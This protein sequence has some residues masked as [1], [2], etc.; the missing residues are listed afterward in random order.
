MKYWLFLCLFFC[1]LGLYAQDIAADTTIYDVLEEMPRFP[2]CE[3]LDTTV[4]AKNTCAQ[5]QLLAFVNKNIVYPV[6]A[7]QLGAEGMVVVKFTVEKDGTLS[8]PSVLKNV[9][10]GCG[11]EVLRVINLMNTIGVKWVPGKLKGEPVRANFT[12]PIRFRLAETPPF[13]MI[14]GDSIWTRVD[15]PLSFK[16][17]TEALYEQLNS[18]LKYP[19]SGI[20]SCLMG[21]IEVKIK[22]DRDASVEVLDMV[23]L[24][25]LGFDFW[26]AATKVV[27]STFGLWEVAEYEG[28]KVPSAFNVNL[29]FFP[30]EAS[31]KEEVENYRQAMLLANEGSVKFDNEEQ[32]LGIEQMTK[33]L[34]L[35]PDNP[36]ILLMRGQAYL[37]LNRFSEA[38]SDLTKAQEVALVNWYD[39]ILPMICKAKLIEEGDLEKKEDGN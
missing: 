22:V 28:Q 25:N 34:D 32:D 23:D 10:G 38:C 29:S 39:D 14:E 18:A 33:A 17:G 21:N 35:L 37:D 6:E 4:A 31:C 30:Q 12:L 9:D 27:T 26:Y 2:A 36:E 15:T 11:A 13:V 8:N 5:Q 1:S 16:E 3:A 19:S 20:D 7:R 24:N